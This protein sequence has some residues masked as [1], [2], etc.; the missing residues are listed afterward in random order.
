[1]R[2]IMQ[3]DPEVCYLCGKPSGAT[4]QGGMDCLE[5]HQIF[6]GNPDR[7]LSVKYGLKIRLH[8]LTCHREAPNMAAYC[9]CCD[10]RLNA[11]YN[12]C[13]DCGQKTNQQKQEEEE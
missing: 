12:F 10:T 4:P 1:M 3:E 7:K 8:A 2:S 5:W 11:W 9:P 13:P 6:E